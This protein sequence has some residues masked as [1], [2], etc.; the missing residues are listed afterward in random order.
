MLGHA[1]HRKTDGLI[2]TSNLSRIS[3][4][5]YGTYRVKRTGHIEVKNA[6][7]FLIAS[8]FALTSFGGAAQPVTLRFD[9]WD[10][11][12]ASVALQHE[13]ANFQR[14]H[15]NIRVKFET[16]TYDQFVQKLLAQFA[17]GVA[18]DVT[19]MDPANFQA[20]AR[21]GAFL[22]LDDFF[23]TTPDTKVK[24]YYPSIVKAHTYKG[25][26]Y[27]LPR[28]IAPE[29][30]V[31]YNKKM[32]RDAG[33]PEPDGKWTWDFVAHP[34]DGDH[35]FL[36]VLKKLQKKNAQGKVVEWGYVPGWPDVLVDM[37]IFGQ[38][39]RYVDD[40]EDPKR[41]NFDDP[42]VQKGFQWYADL[43][44]KDNLIPT[45][46]DLQG[47]NSRQLFTR[48]KVAMF[49][50]GIWE[51]PGLR[52]DLK[53]KGSNPAKYEFDWDIALA[54]GYRN[55]KR[56]YPT[57]GSG[58]AIV[59]STKHPKEAWEL[60]RWMAGPPGMMAMARAGIA[61]PAIR[62]L[63]L[64]EPW[65]PGPNTP[66][67]QQVPHNRIITDQAE[68]YVV[69]PPT[70]ILFSEVGNMARQP[71]N[72]V[73]NGDIKADKA[74]SESQRVSQGRLNTLRK[75]LDL[76]PFNW[77]LGGI[78]GLLIAA[79]IAGWV[80]WPERKQKLTLRE[81][82]EAVAGFVFIG[83][84]LLG[85]IIFVAGPMILSLVMSFA[86]W[87]TIRPA[88]WR[89]LGNYGEAMSVDP[90]FWKSISVTL[91]YTLI[92]V[93]V[94]LAISLGLALLLNTKVKGI[95]IWRTCYYIP[96]I[97]SPIAGSLIWLK[98]FQPEGGLV[99]MLIFGQ[100][101]TGGLPLLKNL[102]APLAGVN[103][104]VNW[105][106][107]EKTAL[108]SMILM[109]VFGA[110]AG[111]LILLAGLQGVPQYY[112][113]AATLDGAGPLRK[114]RNITVPLISPALFFCLI[115]GFIG[116]FQAFTQ[117]FQMTQGGPNNATMFFMLHAY[118]NAFK[119]FRMGYSSALAWVLFVIILIFT[120][121]QLQGN[122][123]VHYEGG[124]R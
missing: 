21:R 73:Y 41:L 79:F 4:G 43:T 87:D 102:M 94:G 114:F 90:V 18:P 80:Y 40:P 44:L 1:V 81:K 7:K 99:N 66:D 119:L 115:T 70:G 88:R 62:R 111:M 65:I 121:I 26:L 36:T 2:E 38:G 12:E 97:A 93:P 55:G 37:A 59:S 106:Q 13:I 52:G 104:Q 74:F 34:E 112:Y 95:A 60:T 45:S 76:P 91:A 67:E 14:A 69:F 19:M 54:P 109:S 49:Q 42:R 103:G 108:P 56:A 110:G 25:K 82:K 27:V 31:Y 61:Q 9:V 68:P 35:D 3:N 75:E 23:A 30:I 63:A 32:F 33:M 10:G 17:A 92:S 101:G 116:S 39:A 118:N 57:G 96:A 117:A 28:D 22:P 107:N 51:V 5:F 50:S 20:F 78:G 85:L 47:T 29:A 100:N 98:L 16:V 84:W 72:S 53:V 120:A 15:P 46:F 24:D 11:N 123:F 77:A 86:D 8:L 124:A 71:A 6:R 83:P 113:E 48:Q 105:L 89:G 64:M 122:R 58:Y